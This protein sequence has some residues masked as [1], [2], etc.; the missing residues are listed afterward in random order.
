[1][2][3]IGERLYDYRMSVDKLQCGRYGVIVVTGGHLDHIRLQPLPKLIGL[4][5]FFWLRNPFHSK[6]VGDRCLLYYNQPRFHSNY[7]ALKHLVST[8]DCSFAS[9]RRAGLVL[10]EI[11][12]LKKSDAILCDAVNAR[13]TD[14]MLR[15]WGWECLKSGRW[16]RQYIKRFYGKYPSP[17]EVLEAILA[18]HVCDKGP[19]AN[20][21]ASC[22]LEVACH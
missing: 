4:P 6:A 15:R 10:D 13:I 1:M 14:Q 21:D 8:S 2:L 5:D 22:E 7:L 16:H 9:V 19:I 11:A 17:P 12:R 18:R 3:S 20:R